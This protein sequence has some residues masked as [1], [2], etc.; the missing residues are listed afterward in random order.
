MSDY[1]YRAPDLDTWLRGRDPASVTLRE[2]F[3]AGER[4]GSDLQRGSVF[5]SLPEQGG[6]AEKEQLPFVGY[7]QYRLLRE[8]HDE[9]PAELPY[10]AGY[11]LRRVLEGLL[12]PEEG[13]QP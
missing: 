2:A 6:E 10:P 11:D 12:W 3:D 1:P 8:Q 4:Y 7:V 13:P 5:L 9:L